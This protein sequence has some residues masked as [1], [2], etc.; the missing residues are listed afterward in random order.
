MVLKHPHG[1]VLV[2]EASFWLKFQTYCNFKFQVPYHRHFITF[3]TMQDVMDTDTQGVRDAT[4]SVFCNFYVAVTDAHPVLRGQPYLTMDK[5]EQQHRKAGL[6]P[7]GPYLG[8]RESI[9]EAV[10]RL[11]KITRKTEQNRELLNSEIYVIKLA[12]TTAG[13][14]KYCYDRQ[15]FRPYAPRLSKTL[16]LGDNQP[17][18]DWGVWYWRG[19]KLVLNDTDDAGNILIFSTVGKLSP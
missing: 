9:E 4:P 16:Y 19:E 14:A 6:V 11:R 3:H 2:F 7:V 12:F 8:L 10:D 17:D 13:F 1:H 15:P 18:T 5:H